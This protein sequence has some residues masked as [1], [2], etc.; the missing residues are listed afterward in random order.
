M[1]FGDGHNVLVTCY[2]AEVAVEWP[3]IY[4][5]HYYIYFLLW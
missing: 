1:N 3:L 4:E 5:G 2:I